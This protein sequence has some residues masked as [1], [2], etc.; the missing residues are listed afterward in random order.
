MKIRKPHCGGGAATCTKASAFMQERMIMPA[1]CGTQNP[2]KKWRLSGRIGGSYQI[3]RPDARCPS[4]TK[5][6][7]Q[8]CHLAKRFLKCRFFFHLFED[9]I[10]GCSWAIMPTCKG[11]GRSTKAGRAPFLYP[12]IPPL[13]FICA[14]SFFRRQEFE[15]SKGALM[16]IPVKA[17]LRFF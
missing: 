6:Q 5:L 11:Q 2:A 16:G 13:F 1:F 17:P 8:I 4:C 9:L 7:E 12:Q 10:F 14:P 15:I 3:C